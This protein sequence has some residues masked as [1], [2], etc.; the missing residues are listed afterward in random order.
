MRMKLIPNQHENHVYARDSIHVSHGMCSD[1]QNVWRWVICLCSGGSFARL[2]SGQAT[3]TGLVR[4]LIGCDDQSMIAGWTTVLALDAKFWTC[5]THPCAFHA[6]MWHLLSCNRGMHACH[7]MLRAHELFLR[8]MTCKQDVHEVS[9]VWSKT[10]LKNALNIPLQHA[11]IYRNFQGNIFE[12]NFCDGIC[13]IKN[14]SQMNC[15]PFCFMPPLV[16]LV[17]IFHF[18]SASEQSC[19]KGRR[20][21]KCRSNFGPQSRIEPG[22][23]GLMCVSTSIDSSFLSSFDPFQKFAPQRQPVFFYDPGQVFLSSGSV[24]WLGA[25]IARGMTLIKGIWYLVHGSK[26]SVSPAHCTRAR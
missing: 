26:Q 23:G 13:Q 2:V 3:D 7:G 10:W 17:E 18:I 4:M 16:V 1:Y 5:A 14:Y 9:H 11:C 8:S 19:S 24:S 6:H 12:Q 25:A 22:T 15:A 20:P 21:I